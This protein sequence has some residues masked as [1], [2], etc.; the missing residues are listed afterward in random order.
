LSGCIQAVQVRHSDIEK[1]NVR[2]QPGGILNRF[3]TIPGLSTD[4]PLRMAFEQGANAFSRY[5]V[6]VRDKDS[7]HAQASPPGT[8]GDLR[9]ES[10]L[11]AA[12]GLRIVAISAGPVV[13]KSL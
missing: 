10:S 5:L 7:K 2:L 4:L 9:G 13:G 11:E 8:N 12:L 1:E 6:I 3:T